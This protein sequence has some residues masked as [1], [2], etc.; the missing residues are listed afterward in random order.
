VIEV[1][2]E[3]WGDDELLFDFDSEQWTCVVYL[4]IYF[5]YAM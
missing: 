5:N 4:V 1:E 2:D 3:D